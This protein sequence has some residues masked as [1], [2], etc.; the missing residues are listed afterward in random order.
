MKLKELMEEVKLDTRWKVDENGELSPCVIEDT[1]EGMGIAECVSPGVAAL[2]THCVNH[3][4]AVVE[5]L[6][7][8]REFIMDHSDESDGSTS[9][10]HI[11]ASKA[12]SDALDA[13][14][15]I[16]DMG[17]EGEEK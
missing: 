10:E 6:E 4:G 14:T 9:R 5:A 1:E 11:A 12:I 8:A 17:K 15:N 16:P 2:I 13:A 3:F 7:D